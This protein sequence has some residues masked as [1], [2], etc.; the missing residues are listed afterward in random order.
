LNLLEQLQ[1]FKDGRN[2]RGQYLKA[3]HESSLKLLDCLGLADI[4]ETLLH[5]AC[6]ISQA[7]DGFIS[8]LEPDHEYFCMRF[9]RG[10]HSDHV[11]FRQQV[12][13]GSMG[14]VYRSRQ[15]HIIDDYRDWGARLR[16]PRL[17][18]FTSGVLVPL[19]LEGQV[20]GI[21]GLSWR[22][23]PKYLAEQTITTIEQYAVMGSIA[24]GNALLYEDA[25][26][27]L[28]QREVAELKA[29]SLIEQ[30][31]SVFNASPALMSVRPVKD[32][33]YNAVNDAW[34]SFFGYQLEEVIGR[35]AEE[36]DIV[37]NLTIPPEVRGRL[38][39][40][41]G[42]VREVL[43]RTKQGVLR[44]L[45]ETTAGMHVDGEDCVLTACIDVTK[46]K[47]LEQE[48][49]RLDRLNLIGEM[50][51]SIGHEVR[52]P[53]T[54]VRGYLQMLQRKNEFPSLANHFELMISELDR[55]NLILTEFL[56]LAKNKGTQLKN[57]NLNRIVGEIMPLI[58][59]RA[60]L[61]G[62]EAKFVGR[63][64]PDL[65]LDEKEIRQVLLNM[66]NNAFEAMT[67]NGC[68]SIETYIESDSVVLAVQDNGNGIS[69][70]VLDKLG[71]PFV[72]TKANGSGLGLPVC[73][74]IA[75]RHKARIE[76]DTSS[77]G[78]TFSIW[79]HISWTD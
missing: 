46:L 18:L 20:V 11:G 49:A 30:L 26:R 14:N 51:A 6:A 54:T 28:E 69:P 13:E 50:A 40:K 65:S 36:L 8:L 27:E 12:S 60:A 3:I 76:V 71:I 52:N 42:F 2:R 68:V 77:A 58:E 16:D 38:A 4:L 25:K 17:D 44:T 72:T 31:S 74:R 5:D 73:Y 64:I 75:E 53:L 57:C 9:G 1:A 10:V 59:A 23:I 24:I 21:L 32:W 7:P 43:V 56:S 37:V 55:A 62:H 34:L 22:N 47:Q 78:T 70:E 61:F 63:P 39:I 35:T 15:T 48:I 41:G 33:R 66:V 45:L 67:T 79:F 19:K 29:Q